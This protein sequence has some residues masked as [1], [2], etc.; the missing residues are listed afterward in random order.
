MRKV[1]VATTAGAILAAAACSS[2]ASHVAKSTRTTSAQSSPTST[3]PRDAAGFVAAVEVGVSSLD[4]MATWRPGDCLTWIP[5]GVGY[6][7]VQHVVSCARPHKVE[8]AGSM[9][10]PARFTKYPTD[11][12]WRSIAQSDCTLQVDE[13][14][15]H[16]LDTHGQYY[17]IALG[18]PASFWGQNRRLLCAIAKR[19]RRAPNADGDLGP[20]V[21]S[22]E[23]TALE[24][25]E[26]V[27]A[28]EDA[29]F[30]ETPCTTPHTWEL[31]GFIDLSGQVSKRPADADWKRVVGDQCDQTARHY[32]GRP[33]LAD[34]QWAF[35]PITPERWA[36]GT[37]RVECFTG[38]V[39]AAGQAVTVTSS[40]KGP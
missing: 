31:T 33:P 20:F 27:G 2:G 5:G 35:N 7:S 13:L 14:F 19:A 30:V 28:C 9:L 3:R 18:P 26:H 12:Q 24:R 10:P 8:I 25:T 17:P 22:V 4:D 6:A 29:N 1:T 40:L 21:G 32:L 39:N 37:R 11:A 36:A 15:G 38:R 23:G 16:T 34:D